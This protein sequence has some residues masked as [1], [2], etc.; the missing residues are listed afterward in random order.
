MIN[1]NETPLYDALVNNKTKHP[2]SFHVPGHKYGQVFSERGKEDYSSLLSIDATEITGL[3]DLHAPDGVIEKAQKLAAHYFNSDFTYFLINGTTVGNLSMILSFCVPGDEII[4]QRNSHKSVLN[5]L[6]LAGAKPVF[7]GPVFEEDTQR[8]S[9]ITLHSVQRALKEHP[10]AKAVFLTYPDYFGRTY[11][12][13]EIIAE[14]HAHGLP[15]CIDEAHGVHFQL[16]EPFPSPALKEGADLVVQSAHKMAPAMTMSSFLHVQGERI[17]QMRL[18]HYLQVLQSSSPSYPLMAS[19]DLARSFLAQWNHLN[20]QQA[21]TSIQEV[22]QVFA[23]Y[24]EHWSVL[25]LSPYDDPLKMTLQTK[26]N[27]GY[28]VMRVLEKMDIHPELA[29][30]DQILLIFG[31]APSVEIHELNQRLNKVDSQ[32]KKSN[33]RATINVDQLSFPE[34]QILEMAYSE[35]QR[36]PAERVNWSEADDYVAAE[37]VIPYPPGIPLLMK[38]ERITDDHRNRVFS[39][40]KQ[41]ARFQNVAIEKGIRVFKGE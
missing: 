2:I 26:R 9:K 8:H 35:M 33:N 11:A 13:G 16:G 21:L 40:I 31:L 24:E 36:T 6:E 1:Q 27:S 18:E 22:R 34:I 39:L 38:G 30:S 7:L 4:V 10:E 23:S 20:K 5:G 14:V 28:E 29:T 15:V 41:G 32:L 12:L 37:A 17:D 19:L 25:P 3:D